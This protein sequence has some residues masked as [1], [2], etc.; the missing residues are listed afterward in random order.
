MSN[1]VSAEA[2][3]AVTGSALLEVVSIVSAYVSNNSLRAA[4][5]P[6]LIAS[7]HTAIRQLAVIEA[8]VVETPAVPIKKS[9]TKD[10]IICLENG[11]KFKSLR[12]H[13]S[14]SY[15]MTPDEYRT[16]WNLPSD[17]PMV[18]PSYSAT[19]SQLARDSGLGQ[20][21]RSDAHVSDVPA[22]MPEPSVDE[23]PVRSEAIEASPEAT[24]P[25]EGSR[26]PRG[27]PRKAA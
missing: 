2:H 27:R 19:R 3:A 16:K 5:L 10:Y 23:P 25:A 13:L 24:A 4:D 17:Y 21:A 26:K 1:D 18:A 11:K 14:S 12:R 8:P 22:D 15:N 9:V 20:I 7:V 6:D